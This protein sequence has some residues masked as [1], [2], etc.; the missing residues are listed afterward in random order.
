MEDTGADS[1]GTSAVLGRK[2]SPSGASRVGACSVAAVYAEP[3]HSETA[4]ACTVV[5]QLALFT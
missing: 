3:R 4:L 2:A 1:G 5:V